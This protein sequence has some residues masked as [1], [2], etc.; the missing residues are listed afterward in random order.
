MFLHHSQR[1]FSAV[2]ELHQAPLA[3]VVQGDMAPAQLIVSTSG[4]S[5]NQAPVLVS[6]R[7][8]SAAL[9]NLTECAAE[10]RNREAAYAL[11]LALVKRIRR[12]YR[13]WLTFAEQGG[14]D[15]ATEGWRAIGWAGW[16]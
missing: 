3:D 13:T 2:A 16:D 12:K 5:A 10:H 11:M 15:T 1:R 14:A 8:A 6:L 9:I 7:R 4:T